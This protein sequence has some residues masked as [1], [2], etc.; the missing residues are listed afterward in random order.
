MRKKV[1]RHVDELSA[2]ERDKHLHRT[3]GHKCDR[4]G[5]VTEPS[6]LKAIEETGLLLVL[7]TQCPRCET[8]DANK[9]MA[10]AYDRKYPNRRLD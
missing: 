9:R 8:D 6:Q 1:T 5:C 4:D 7:N 2:P 10:A 3:C